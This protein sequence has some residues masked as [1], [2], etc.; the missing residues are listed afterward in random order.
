MARYLRRLKMPFGDY[1]KT[2]KHHYRTYGEEFKYQDFARSFTA[3]SWR[4]TEW[5]RLFKECGARYVVLTAKHH[6]GF[7]LWPWRAPKGSS[8]EVQSIADNWTAGVAGP[9]RDLVGELA[10]AVRAAGLKFGVYYR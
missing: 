6:D 3:S 4:P 9:K 2:R 10:R 7:C 1:S 8:P 5:A